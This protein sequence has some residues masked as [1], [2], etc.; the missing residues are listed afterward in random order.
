MAHTQIHALGFQIPW[1]TIYWFRARDHGKL[2][3]TIF[4]HILFFLALEAITI[5]AAS[6]KTSFMHESSVTCN[7]LWERFKMV[8][9]RRMVMVFKVFVYTQAE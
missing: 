1:I 3:V 9:D 4:G 5:T 8:D 2:L 7:A 6:Y